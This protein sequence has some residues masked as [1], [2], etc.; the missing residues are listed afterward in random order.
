VPDA[1][2]QKKE[3]TT[4]SNGMNPATSLLTDTKRL[5]RVTV[6]NLRQNHIYINGHFD[7]FPSDCIGGAKRS[8]QSGQTIEILLDG[9]DQTVTTDIG[10]DAKKDKPRSFFR[11][12]GWVREFYKHHSVKAGALLALE[13]LSERT[14][15]LSVEHPAKP[16]P[17]VECAELFAGIGLVRL[18]LERQ[19]W[20]VVFAND[21]DPK[22][23]E[24]YR[25]NWP[26]DDHLNVGD[27]HALDPAALPNCTLYT[28]SF[29]CNDLSIAGR[30]E[31][32]QGKES[33]SFWGL[34]QKLDDLGNRRPPF[35]MLE[36]VVGFLM[37][38]GG[39]DFE[40]ALLAMN[41]LGYTVDAVVLNATHWVPQSRPRLFV[42]ARRD[43]GRD[44]RTF[45]LAS[46]ARPESLVR[47]IGGHPNI[48]WDIRDLPALPKP[49]TG[50]ADIV[51]DLPK[52]DPHWWSRKRADY[53]MN[54]MSAKH[55]AQA[56]EMIAGRSYTFATAF[57]RVRYGKSMAE[58]RTDGI[59]GCLRTPRGG[60]G[61][62][63]LFK[64]G[65]GKYQVRLLT[66]RECA[67]L[68]GVPDSYVIDVPLNQALFGFGDAVC[69]PVIEWIVQHYLKPVVSALEPCPSH[70]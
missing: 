68:Q 50:L 18:A 65:R 23:A 46:D 36:N 29:P 30:W 7:F 34:V 33:S 25:H 8:S 64:G 26:T 38:H 53:F 56:R 32:L 20:R 10:R 61:R 47:F 54:Q 2:N 69:V 1:A 39:R 11:S 5:L 41:K 4:G 57:R 9:L 40:E 19:G 49:A 48:R 45:A 15:R 52:D 3:M 17:V 43:E 37:S 58:L 16:A 27:I 6:G 31:G 51:E 44:S 12:R 21:I 66:A 67:R 24:M 13:R 22:K 28:A 35:V 70:G 42:L 62:Q 55:V 59:A 60:S 63:I 14:Y